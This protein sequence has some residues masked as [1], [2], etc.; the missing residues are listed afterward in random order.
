MV[1]AAMFFDDGRLAVG[2]TVRGEVQ[3]SGVDPRSQR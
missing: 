2:G 3:R 1:D